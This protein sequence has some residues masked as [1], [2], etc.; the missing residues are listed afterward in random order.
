MGRIHAQKLAARGDVSFDIVDPPKGHPDRG[1]ALPDFAIVATPTIT[2]AAVALPLLRA[3]VPCLIEKP[4]ADTLEN[5]RQLAAFPHV[6]VGHVERHNPTLVPIQQAGCSPRFLQAERLS[7]YQRRGTDVDVIADLMIHD[8]DLALWLLGGAVKDVRAVGVGVM[9]GGADIVN[10]RVEL[11]GGIATLTASR[12]SHRPARSLRLVESGCYWSAD[13]HSRTLH[14]VRWGEQDLT[15]EPIPV[16]SLDA[17]ECE[18]N[19]FLAAVRGEAD[20]PCPG[21]DAVAAIALA[22]QIRRAL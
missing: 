17:I 10:A 8:I 2:H 13:L 3:G 22:E 5:A 15:P 21:A 20:Y 7:P 1:G 4:L 14:R 12:V 19:A 6:S 11:E 9:T 18:Q 16:P